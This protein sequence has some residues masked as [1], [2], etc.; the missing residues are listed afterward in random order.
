MDQ[1]FLRHFL[2]YD[3]NSR[4][5]YDALR[6]ICICL[7]DIC[8]P[9]CACAYSIC[10]CFRSN[11]QCNLTSKYFT[12]ISILESQTLSE[13]VLLTDVFVCWFLCLTQDNSTMSTSE[14]T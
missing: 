9:C 1:L 8:V 12:F 3:V 7:L 13:L 5:L 14:E 6:V 10:V 4:R 11:I 2:S